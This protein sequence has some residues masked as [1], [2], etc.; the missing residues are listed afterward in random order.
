M[1][2]LK[3]CAFYTLGCKVNQYETQYMRESLI[4]AGY[5]EQRFNDVCD[6]YIVNT[7]TVTAKADKESRRVIRDAFRRNPDATIC[8]TGCY[9]ERD[10][11]DINKI[12]GRLLIVRNDQKDRICQAINGNKINDEVRK[13]NKNRYTPLNISD[14]KGRDRAFV[15]IQDGCDNHCAYCKIPLVRGVSRSRDS[16]SIL[17]EIK[18]LLSLGFKEIVLTGI[19]LGAWG[20]D[21]IPR[22]DLST[23]LHR[24]VCLSGDFRVRLSSIEPKFITHSLLSTISSAHKICKHLHIPFQSGDDE[25][26]KAMNRPY[27]FETYLNLVE[28]IRRNIPD[29]SI[30]TDILV[31]FPGETERHFAKTCKLVEEIRPL[32]THI[33]SYSRRK[34]TPAS[35]LKNEIPKSIVRQRMKIVSRLAAKVSED[36][37]KEF[38]LKKSRLLIESKRD[39]GTGMLQGY[40]DKYFRIFVNGPNYYM[41][42]FATVKIEKV[43]GEH[44]IGILSP[45]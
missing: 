12:P 33:F 28:I 30:T 15:K 10:A 34:G 27:A 25:I 14:F 32:R 8:V 18:R 36:Y 41:S 26:L 17:A 37:R 42:T 2:R 31:G 23:L 45:Q 20:R 9:V 5:R 13:D 1:N 44:T 7:C 22:E 6:L 11:E 29:I 16:Y 4:K 43:V 21:L 39:K 40:D 38:L 19:C 24:I 3:T 35:L